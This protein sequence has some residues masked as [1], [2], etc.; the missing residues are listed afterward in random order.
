MADPALAA[1]LRLGALA[2]LARAYV[3][4]AADVLAHPEDEAQD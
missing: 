4:G 1:V 2:R 3:L